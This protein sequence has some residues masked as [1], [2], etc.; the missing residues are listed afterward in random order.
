M[1]F[2]DNVEVLGN[3][4]WM[5]IAIYCK[6]KLIIAK[7]I[8]KKALITIVVSNHKTLERMV[9]K[10]FLYKV[11]LSKSSP[12]RLNA[13]LDMGMCLLSSKIPNF[14]RMKQAGAADGSHVTD[15]RSGGAQLSH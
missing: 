7:T 5:V 11:G 15:G 12:R 13:H 8:V 4:Y 3:F 6:K 2:L 10:V 14:S 1:A 9:S